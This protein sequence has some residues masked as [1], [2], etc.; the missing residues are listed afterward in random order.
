MPRKS[1]IFYSVF[2]YCT[3]RFSELCDELAAQQS[4]EEILGEW[5]PEDNEMAQDLFDQGRYADLERFFIAKIQA[6]LYYNL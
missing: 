6:P 4:L 1:K 5:L 2:G 3:P